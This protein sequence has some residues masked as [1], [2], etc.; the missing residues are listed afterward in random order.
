LQYFSQTFEQRL[1]PYDFTARF[2]LNAAL[3]EARQLT[4]H[5]GKEAHLEQGQD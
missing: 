3:Q 1:T 5:D 2:E 4:R